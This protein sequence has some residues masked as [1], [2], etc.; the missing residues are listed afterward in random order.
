MT[1][2]EKIERAKTQLPFE[3]DKILHQRISDVVKKEKIDLIIELGSEYCSTTQVFASLVDS[4]YAVEVDYETYKIAKQI[5]PVNAMVLCDDSRIVLP[6]ILKHLNRPLKFLIYLDSH[7]DNNCPILDELKI[8][9][10]S[11][12]KPIILIHDFFRSS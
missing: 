6:F 4:V 11:G 3:G 8:I 12:I 2:E 1:Y 5:H 10:A 9:A 7:S